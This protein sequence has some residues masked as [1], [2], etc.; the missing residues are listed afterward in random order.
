MTE[1]RHTTQFKPTALP[2]D[3]L[4]MVAE[5]FSGHF[6]E[7]IATLKKKGLEPSFQAIGSFYPDEIVLSI[8]LAFKDQMAATTVHASTDYDPAASA[9]TPEELLSGCV[10]AAGAVYDVIFKEIDLLAQG[11]LTHIPD[12][13]LMWSHLEV[14]KRGVYVKAD[15][16]NVAL[17]QA[18]DEWLAKNDPEYQAEE[19]QDQAEAVDQMA[20]R[21][22]VSPKSKHTKH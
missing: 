19:N 10:D 2:S 21:L 9:P 15:K 20:E 16:A 12:V 8:S 14:N 7:K 11:D 5:V 6:S 3:Y 4:K 22:N 1:R 18:A 17:D 13:P